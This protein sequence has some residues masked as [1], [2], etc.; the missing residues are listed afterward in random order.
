MVFRRLFWSA[1]VV[2]LLVPCTGAADA[3]SS[4]SRDASGGSPAT[5]T[6]DATKAL[7]RT[8]VSNYNRGRVRVINRLWAPEPRFQWFSTGKPGERI[9]PQAYSRASL[10]AYFRKRVRKH[11]RL[12]LTELAAGYDAARHILHFGGMLVRSGDDMGD[13]APQH[14]KGAADCVSRRPSLIVWSM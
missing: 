13:R 10:A 2:A 8:F 3:V 14:F 9:A 6:A 4:P 5:C 12:Q 11:E 1:G 7:V